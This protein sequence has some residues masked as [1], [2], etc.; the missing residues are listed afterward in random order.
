MATFPGNGNTPPIYRR[1]IS[2]E[3]NGL[4]NETKNKLPLRENPI[5]KNGDFL[6]IKGYENSTRDLV[7]SKMPNILQKISTLY[8]TTSRML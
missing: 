8:N 7:N 6:G 3:K 2:V 5:N 1:T 4:K